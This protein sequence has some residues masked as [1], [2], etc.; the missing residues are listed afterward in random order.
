MEYYSKIVPHLAN[1]IEPT[2]KLLHK[3][4]LF[5]W[6]KEA[7]ASFCEVKKQ[8]ASGRVLSMFN[9]S[10]SLIVSTDASAYALEAV[11]QQD[12]SSATR[13]VA[14]ASRSLTDVEC[15]YS[16]EERE[17]LACLGASENWHV[18]L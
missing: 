14:F 17:T 15:K 7:K 1:V 4:A 3:G 11:L 9:P 8:L 5:H 10:L 16:T 18:Y 13:S 2:C 12:S 6:G